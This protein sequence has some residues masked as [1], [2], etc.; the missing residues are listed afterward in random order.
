MR[1]PL[2]EP[3]ISD[4]EQQYALDVLNG[5]WLSAGGKHTAIFEGLFANYLGT[6]NAIAVQSGT[7]ALHLALKAVGVN[8]EDSVILPNYS[9]GASIS[10][11]AQC[12][13]KPIVMDIE[14]E[15]YG[16]DA[17]DLEIVVNK[18]KPKA[19]Q[20]VH[21]YGF[22]ARDTLIIKEIC[23]KNNVMLIEDASEALGAELGGK[24]IGTFGD[25]GTFSLRSEKMI[26][27]GEGG[28]VVT[29]N[30]LLSD[31]MMKLASRKVG[32]ISC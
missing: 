1:Y 30:D 5:N 28:V 23:S 32:N 20:L 12:G 13:A 21:V 10:A 3:D 19:L 8:N 17:T 26:G 18:Y 25:I 16:L 22:P 29:D 14:L 31:E 11:V 4:L 2:N 7:A 9:C 6:A 15:T 27:I 24:K